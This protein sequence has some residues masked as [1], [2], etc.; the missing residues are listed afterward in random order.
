MRSEHYQACICFLKLSLP[1]QLEMSEKLYIKEFSNRNSQS[2][3]GI[4][5]CNDPV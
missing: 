2:E 5:L 3:I 1:K 4:K